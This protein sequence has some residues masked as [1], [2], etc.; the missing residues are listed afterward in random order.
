MMN[1][2]KCHA[3]RLE[4]LEERNLLNAAPTL[5]AV[6]S[7]TIS[8]GSAYYLVLDGQDADGDTLTYQVSTSN[9][10]LEYQLLE[11]ENNRS[12]AIE[13]NKGTMTFQL[14]EELAPQT[15]ARILDLVERGYF[16]STEDSTLLFHRVVEN[17]CIQMGVKVDANG[18]TL[19]TGTGTTIDDEFDQWLRFTN[20]GVLAMAKSSFDDTGDAQLFITTDRQASLDYNYSIFGFQTDGE[21]V[22]S[23]IQSVTVDDNDKPTTDVVVESV[24]VVENEG[25]SVLLLN[26][27]SNITGTFT[28]TVTVDDG[29][30]GTTTKEITVNAQL[31]THTYANTRPFLSTETNEAEIRVPS[32]GTTSITLE[33]VNNDSADNVYFFTVSSENQGVSATVD[34]QTGEVTL[35]PNED[36]VGVGTLFVCVTDATGYTSYNASGSNFSA[37]YDSQYLPVFVS[38][39]ATLSPRLVSSAKASSDLDFLVENISPG[40]TVNLYIDGVLAGTAK[41]TDDSDSI[42]ITTSTGVDFS[43]GEHTVYAIQTLETEYSVANRSGTAVLTSEASETATF[44][45]TTSPVPVFAEVSPS[46]KIDEE[47]T[48]EFTVSATDPDTG[49]A[50]TVAVDES[51]LPAGATFDSTTGKFTWTPTEAQ[52]PGTFTVTFTATNAGG[53]TTYD[54][55]L[56]VGEV[57]QAPVLDAI[58]N[59]TAKEYEEWT[60]TL[61][62]SDADRPAET[63]T[64]ALVSDVPDGMTLQADTGELRWTPKGYTEDTTVSVTVS[65]T[66][67]AGLSDTQTFTIAVENAIDPPT[68]NDITQTTVDEGETLE[69]TVSATDAE[70]VAVDE[71]TL[72]AGAT[73]DSTTG[74]FTWTPTEAQGPGTFTVTFTATN[75]GGTTT[76]DVTLTVGEVSQAPVLDAIPNQTAKEYEEWTLTLSASDADRPAETL[77][78]A[79]VSDVP[80]GMTLQAD[81]GE[82]RWTPKGYTEDTTVSVTVSVTDA[83]GLS[84]TQTFTIAVE[85]AIDPPTFN[86]ITQTTVDEGET[87]EF[88]VSATD[89]ETVAVDESTLPAGATF[90][91]TTGKFTWTPTESQGPGTFTVTF[92]ATNAGGTTTHDVTLTVGEVSQAPVLDAIDTLF[93]EELEQIL[94]QITASDADLP[95]NKLTYAFVSAVPAGMTLDPNTGLISWTPRG[96]LEDTTFT[97][98]VEVRDDTGLTDTVT[99]QIQVKD[100]PVTVLPSPT[101][102]LRN[103]EIAKPRANVMGGEHFRFHE[104][105]ESRP[106]V[107]V[108]GENPSEGAFGHRISR[109]SLSDSG[110][111]SDFGQSTP[112]EQP[113]E[114]SG[115]KKEENHRETSRWK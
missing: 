77:T 5:T 67:A 44:T 91:S 25:K 10:Y 60:L 103:V 88:T 4:C 68:F 15:T 111:L 98:S 93:G 61:S 29:N 84:D 65:V 3:L 53:T 76:Y 43:A 62:A 7:V 39:T 20:G 34:N 42:L 57:S 17:F 30:G 109:S 106:A 46:P 48:L 97:L 45:L 14:F 63:L 59:Q 82:L 56:T 99:F 26:V 22:R 70:T 50:V 31:D 23:A 37:Y 6:D 2:R 9:K 79:L 110:S 55:T 94:V 85:N 41:N 19:S 13:T 114:D 66:D 100:V 24:S 90:D 75:A 83:A 40:V 8:S 115:E 18:E 89:A 38:P 64:Y 102:T 51:T 104:R 54:V 28:V 11:A 80:D 86:D 81:T 52:G 27:P 16:N 74:K 73:F 105:P 35:T 72:P 113:A 12:I 32:G 49:D 78:Y 107:R 92:T 95:A 33:A 58:P 112:Q 71:S 96:I 47:E 108:G 36:F 87:L 69:F 21:E 101:E 1:L